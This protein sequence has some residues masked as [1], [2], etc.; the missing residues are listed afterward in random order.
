MR[1]HFVLQSTNT[2]LAVGAYDRSS[3]SNKSGPLPP[4]RAMEDLPDE[5]DET[6]LY[7]K[8]KREL[9]DLMKQYSNTAKRV[10]VQLN[11]TSEELTTVKAQLQQLINETEVM[12]YD[13][14]M[15]F[16]V[17]TYKKVMSL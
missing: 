1:R 8:T 15:D 13:S 5:I 6:A 12:T 9:V 16:T 7:R 4:K 17:G 10:K 2:D 14:L 11:E 3:L